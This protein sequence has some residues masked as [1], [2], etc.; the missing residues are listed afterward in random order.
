MAVR[1]HVTNLTV[2]KNNFEIPPPFHLKTKKLIVRKFKVFY[3]H[4]RFFFCKTS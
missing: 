1:N 4:E 3:G 2:N